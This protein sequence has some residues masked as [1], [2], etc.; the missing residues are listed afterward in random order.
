M[1]ISIRLFFHRARFLKSRVAAVR[2]K[3]PVKTQPIALAIFRTLPEHSSLLEFRADL[4][5]NLVTINRTRQNLAL[6][7]KKRLSKES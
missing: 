4:H 5:A 6:S 7:S 3:N 2:I 1:L